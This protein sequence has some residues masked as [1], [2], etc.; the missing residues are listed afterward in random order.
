MQLIPEENLISENGRLYELV[1]E[2]TI[3]VT[4]PDETLSSGQPCT[5][6]LHFSTSSQGQDMDK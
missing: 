1:V 2:S 6:S 4:C 5:L 3:P